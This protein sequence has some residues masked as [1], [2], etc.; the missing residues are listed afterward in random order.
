MLSKSKVKSHNKNH[1]NER[2][3]YLSWQ[4]NDINKYCYMIRREHLRF[5]SYHFTLN[6]SGFQSDKYYECREHFYD[7]QNIIDGIGFVKT[8]LKE[9]RELVD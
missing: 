7:W 9:I 1:L 8:E 4:L 6:S 5:M 3:A 2:L